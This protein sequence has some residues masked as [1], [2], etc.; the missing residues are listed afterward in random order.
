MKNIIQEKPNTKLT[1][2]L[3]KTFEFVLRE[4]IKD[5]SILDIG[6][7]YGWF[8]V[9]A[10]KKGARRIFGAEVSEDDLST[11]KK[12]IRNKNFTPLIGSSS[13][14]PLKNSSMDTVVA[15]EVIEHIPK[16]SE[17]KFFKEVA[18]LLKKNGTFYLSTPHQSF[19]S[20]YLDPAFWLIGHRHYSEGQLRSYAIK[21]GFVVEDVSIAGGIWASLSILNM[22]ISKWIFRKDR[23]L[24]SFFIN[25]ENKEYQRKGFYN[26]FVKYRKVS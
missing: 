1:G 20:T 7:G 4:D 3:K 17:N 14:I 26:I 11:I 24:K 15:W 2:R 16:G 5:K 10:F 6:C 13:H 8:E 22:Y 19:F 9:N 18:R 21:N 12:Y 23:F 25:K